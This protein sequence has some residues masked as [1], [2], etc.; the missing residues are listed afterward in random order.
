MSIE[1]PNLRTQR[2]RAE[3]SPS[4]F[5]MYASRLSAVRLSRLFRAASQLKRSLIPGY[6]RQPSMRVQRLPVLQRKSD[7]ESD[8]P[9]IAS[10]QLLVQHAMQ[11]QGAFGIQMASRRRVLLCHRGWSRFP[12]FDG[13][14]LP[15]DLM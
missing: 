6:E 3:I 5:L 10:R 8:Y 11:L 7:V 1:R 15:S 12:H 2:R 14:L 13:F 4:C 9:E